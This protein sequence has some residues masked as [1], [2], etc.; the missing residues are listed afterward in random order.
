MNPIKTIVDY[1][2]YLAPHR[3]TKYGLLLILLPVTFSWYKY[4]FPYYESNKELVL[5]L[6]FVIPTL[7]FIA[8]VLLSGRFL[9]PTKKF[10]VI[11]S[12][13]ANDHKSIKH[14]RNAILILN[15]MLDSVGLLD[16]FRI[17]LIG[18]SQFTV[19]G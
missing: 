12:L 10:T 15:N 7:L 19:G 18:M 5:I 1:L 3:N 17:K 8:W 14:I 6:T 4:I 16:K 13:K 9:L 2:N 11:F